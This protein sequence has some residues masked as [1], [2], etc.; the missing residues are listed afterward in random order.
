MLKDEDV[1]FENV[2]DDN[3]VVDGP[4][5]D[6]K[7]TSDNNITYS[8]STVSTKYGEDMVNTTNFRFYDLEGELILPE[9]AIINRF[10]NQYSTPTIKENMTVDMSFTPAQM[11]TDSYWGDGKNFVITSQEIDFQMCRQEITILEKK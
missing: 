9:E 10:V 7:I 4:E 3:N 1:C 2:I 8:F 6:L 5:I 11:V